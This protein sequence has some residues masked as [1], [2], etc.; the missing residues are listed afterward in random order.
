MDRF[1]LEAIDLGK[2]Y[3]MKIRHDN[4]L[5]NP[6]WFL[7][8]VEVSDG[9]DKYVFH[10]ERWLAKNKEDGKIERTLYVKG[11]DGDMSSSTGTLRS[12]RFEGSVASLNSM[13]TS[14]RPSGRQ[15]AASKENIPEGPTIPYTV[16]VST[17]DGEDN[18]TDSNVWIR[19]HGPGKKQT[20][21][22]FLELVQ[23]ERFE[24]SSV[25]TFSIEGVDVGEIRSI[26]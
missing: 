18:G 7:D 21:R 14:P 25:E 13:G 8:R 26:E 19:I 3:K 24:P 20:G 16:K 12:Q 17:G 11:Y 6:A 4:S 2:L 9:R 22:K 10:C 23:Q 1:V 15:Q 5:I